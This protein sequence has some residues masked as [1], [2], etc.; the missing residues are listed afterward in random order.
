MIY[1]VAYLLIGIGSGLIA[2][3]YMPEEIPDGPLAHAAVGAAGGLLGG[4]LA[5]A[6]F[7]AGNNYDYNY[8]WHFY[9]DGLTHPGTWISLI[10]SMVGAVL[11]LACYKLVRV[12]R[13][14]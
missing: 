13:P 5:R 8:G 7:L 2:R 3:R 9:Q 11:L 10:T 6:M 1:L 4:Y 12:T 14:L